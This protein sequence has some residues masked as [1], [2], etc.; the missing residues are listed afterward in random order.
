MRDPFPPPSGAAVLALV[1]GTVLLTRSELDHGF[2]AAVVDGFDLMVHEA[3]HPILGLLG[4]RS[5]M[6]LGG[7]LVQLAVPLAAAAAFA[8]GRQPASLA[9]AAVWLGVNL[10]NVG[11]YCADAEAR[12]LPLLAV[13]ADAHDWWNMLGMLGIRS[14]GPSIGHGLAALGWS[15]HLAAPAWALARWL[16][17]RLDAAG[18]A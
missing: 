11:T 18:S 5:L 1:A 12:A 6:F 14:W 17:T 8:V 2:L 13:D 16:G 9:T 15:L 7:T 3:G 10:V 4:S